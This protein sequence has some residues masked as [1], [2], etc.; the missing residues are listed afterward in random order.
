MT[1]CKGGCGVA[2]PRDDSLDCYPLTVSVGGAN[3]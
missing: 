3:S 2:L 1:P